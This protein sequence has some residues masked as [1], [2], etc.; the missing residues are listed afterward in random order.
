[1]MPPTN[2][3]LPVGDR[4]GRRPPTGLLF[5]SPAPQLLPAPLGAGSPVV[6]LGSYAIEVY[7]TTVT[8]AEQAAVVLQALSK[9]CPELT[10][11]FD[12]EDCDR[13]LCLRCRRPGPVC[14]D[15]A[16]AVVR[17]LGIQIAVLPE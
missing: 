14:W 10:A 12:L 3:P 13:I 16:V 4:P 7:R 8:S 2:H 5:L 1:M 17:N 6:A 11:S 15:Q 9:A